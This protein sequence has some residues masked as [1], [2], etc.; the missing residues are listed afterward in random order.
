MAAAKEA[1]AIV[2]DVGPGMTEAPPGVETA[3]KSSVEAIKRILQRKM[4]S[5]SKDEIALVLFGTEGT[6]NDLADHDNYQH[7]TLAQPL[8]LVSWELLHYVENDI[9][10]SN[11]SGDFLDAI[12]VAVDHLVR[13]VQGK[14]GFGTKRIVLFSNFCGE[15]GDDQIDDII[16]S[17]IEVNINLNIIGPALDSD[18]DVDNGDA[19]PGPSNGHV[20]AKS[21][22]QR[23]GEKMAQYILEKIRGESFSFSEALP[24]LSYFQSRQVKSAAW[25]CQLEIGSDL[26]IPICL[27]ARVKEAKSNTFETVYAKDAD[28][29]IE[30]LRTYHLTDD[31]E[32]EIEKSD[33][34]DGHRYGSTLVPFSK[35]DK[36]TMKYKTTK[37]FTL[38]CFVSADNVPCHMLMGDGTSICV[39]EKGDEPAAVALSALI[40]A[41]YELNCVAIVRRVYAANAQVHVGCLKPY[42]KTDYECLIYNELP[43]SEDMRQ[44]TFGSLPLSEDNTAARQKLAPTTE[45]LS[46]VDQLIDSMDL[47]SAIKDEDGEAVE[48]LKPKL[49]FNPYLQ[50]LYQCLQHRALNPDEPLPAL[51]D[52]IA[53]SMKVPEAVEVQCQA[54]VDK[55][56][57]KFKLELVAKEKN[58]DTGENIFKF[59]ENEDKPIEKKAKTENDDDLK[60]GLVNLIKVKEVG[61][62]SPVED[63]MQ[64][65]NQKDE[66]LFEKACQMMEKRI[67]QLV[68]D[69]FGSQSYPKAMDCLK[70]LREAAVKNFEPNMFNAFMTEL[71]E[72]LIKVCRRDFWDTIVHEKLTLISKVESEESKIS[73]CESEDFLQMKDDKSKEKESTAQEGADDLLDDI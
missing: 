65:I 5:Q 47:A 22:Q 19:K 55:M 37:C 56:K 3:L 42:I 27:Y 34:I 59:G 50:R 73:Q 41:M 30:R 54:T 16:A 61:T 38:L 57:D 43:F 25:K 7:V 51:S 9:Q 23:T 35:D 68:T 48:T 60:G 45:Q 33:V 53:G 14:K 63:F 62:V 26:H 66:D 4:F 39:A 36:E 17:M 20:K 44:F 71:K 1:I 40:N 21:P 52:V 6:A 67:I 24:A 18:G 58:D 32:T 64:L 8:G 29:K 2:L 15:F 46:L 28:A 31:A 72:Q 13:T 69:S 12:V 49:T 10:P 11:T 70:A